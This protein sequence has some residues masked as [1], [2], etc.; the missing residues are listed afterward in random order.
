MSLPRIPAAA[1][2]AAEALDRAD[3]KDDLEAIWISSGCDNFRG[4]ARSYLMGIYQRVCTRID[5][6]AVWLNLARAM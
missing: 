5:H 4:A 6:N 3:T 2:I 1:V